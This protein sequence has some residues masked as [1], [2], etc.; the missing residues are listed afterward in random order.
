MY[1]AKI[2]L[3]GIN[4]RQ[5]RQE[6]NGGRE[7]T[8]FLAMLRDVR[9][10]KLD[11]SVDVSDE[12]DFPGKYVSNTLRLGFQRRSPGWRCSSKSVIT[13]F[14]FFLPFTLC[15]GS[16]CGSHWG[17]FHRYISRILIVWLRRIPSRSVSSE[18]SLMAH[19][20]ESSLSYRALFTM[21]NR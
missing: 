2:N 14:L 12:S 1:I 17:H 21:L 8:Q 13:V 6:R 11:L 7:K 3:F 18:M 15:S 10:E 9:Y 19:N 4:R 16:F 5:E 20:A